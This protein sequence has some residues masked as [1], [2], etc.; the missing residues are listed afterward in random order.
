[1]LEK[2]RKTFYSKCRNDSN[3]K[4]L[5]KKFSGNTANL[6]DVENYSRLL[7]NMLSQAFLEV[8][9][10]D[11]LPN[12]KLYYNIAK[13]ILEPMLRDNY[14]YVNN[15]ASKVQQSVDK[16]D[17]IQIKPQ[18]SEFP[19]ERIN[20]I[21]NAVSDQTADW[22]TIQRRLDSPIRNIT[23]SFY[24]DYIA[25]NVKFRNDAGLR[26]YIT[27]SVSGNCCKWCSALA[28][29]YAYSDAPPDIYRRHDNCHCT[30][31]YENG[32]TRQDVWSKKTWQVKET[33]KENYKPV[34]LSSEQAK[35]LE[36]KNLQYKGIDNSKKNDIINIEQMANLM[37]NASST[38][39]NIKLYQRDL[40]IREKIKSDE[41]I[42]TINKG[43]QDKHMLNT[44]EYNQYVEKLKKLG[45]YG[46][47]R[48]TL[49]QD[50][51]AVLIEK[52]AGTGIIQYDKNGNWRN[53]EIITSCEKNI[54]ICVNNLTGKEVETSVFMIKYSNNGVHVIPHYPKMKGMKPNK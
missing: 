25:E 17:N 37:Y 33:S 35:T 3:I 38:E 14:N 11:V 18:K 31:T 6:L 19:L 52:Y 9:T 41:I 43:Q 22:E 7:G 53:S 2:V 24:D 49:S 45:Q 42:K 50:E 44:H 21:I 28:G 29:R 20:Q 5:L 12:Q 13:T 48:I 39:E 16:K 8:I 26:C 10:P 47:S 54:G 27:R 32:K 51:I 34:K 1:M 40:P 36:Q 4:N 46:P 15:V 23:E 30:V